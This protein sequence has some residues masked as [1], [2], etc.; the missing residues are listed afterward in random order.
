VKTLGSLSQT[1]LVPLHPNSSSSTTF[2][3]SISLPPNLSLLAQEL[4]VDYAKVN[5]TLK[6][7]WETHANKVDFVL[8]VGV[9]NPLKLETVARNGP[10]RGEDN[11]KSAPTGGV[12]SICKIASL[13]FI[14][15]SLHVT[16][17]F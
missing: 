11:T 6:S 16:Y 1:T 10:F 7:L 12:W 13:L 3:S 4:P 9:G 14:S 15:Q 5:A 8:H 17:V 2:K